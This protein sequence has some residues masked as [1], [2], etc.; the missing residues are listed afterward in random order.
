MDLSGEVVAAQEITW[1]KTFLE[2]DKTDVCLTM[3]LHE[4]WCSPFAFCDA[5]KILSPTVF[6]VRTRRLLLLAAVSSSDSLPSP[7]HP[8]SWP[9]PYSH[10]RRQFSC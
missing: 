6:T 8:L 5:T 2:F 1:R 3:E 7:L 9:H 10:G 4:H